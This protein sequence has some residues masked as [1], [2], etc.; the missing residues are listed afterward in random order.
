MAGVKT[1]Q[2]TAARL[3]RLLL[4]A[5]LTAFCL[6]LDSLA[7]GEER[8]VIDPT[9]KGVGYS[10]VLYDNTGGLPTSE[11]NVIAATPDGFLWIGGYAGLIRYDGNIFERLDSTTGLASVVSLL[12]DSKERLWVGTNESGLGLLEKG[13]LRMYRKADGLPSLSVRSI[14]EDRDGRI[15]IGTT[16]GIVV[17]QESGDGAMTMLPLDEPALDDEYIRSLKLGAD[18][19][20]YGVTK[21]GDV[22]TVQDGKM[23]GFYSSRELQLETVR[24]VLPDPR[25]PGYVYLAGNGPDLCYGRLET[26]FRG[27]EPIAVMSMSFVNSMDL[28]DDIIW[29]CADDGIGLVKDG[30]FESLGGVPMITSVEQVLA[31]YQGNLWFV[32]SQQGVMKIV[33][34]QFEDIFEENYMEDQVVY[35]TCLYNGRL[36][37]GTKDSGLVV[38]QDSYLIGELPLESAATASGEPTMD[39]DLLNTLNGVK[40]RS[41]IRD[42]QNRL[43][44]STF[45]ETS[46]M[47]YDGRTLTRFTPEDGLPSNRVRTVFE[48]RDGTF[49]AACTG[50]LAVI[51]GD[52]V[53]RVY[54]AADGIANTEI[55]TVCETDDGALLLGTD[56]GGIYAIRGEELER[57]DTDSGLLSDV[58]MRV[59]RDRTRNLY[60][61]V[62]SNSLAYMTS[63]GQIT[64]VQKFP[65]SNNFDLYENSRDEMWVLSSNGIYVIP[66]EE[67]LAN[68]EINPVYYS[69]ANGLPC[70]STANS[71]SELTETGDLYLSGTTGVAKVNIDEPFDKVSN[72]RMSVPYLEVDGERVYPDPTGVFTLPSGVKRVTVN[73]YVFT[74]SLTDP[75]VTYFLEGFEQSGTTVPR[76]E[77]MP[78]NYTN[79][80]GGEYRFVM[81]LQDSTGQIGS[82]L[83]VGIVKEKSIREMLWYQVFQFILALLL[84]AAIIQFRFHRKHQALLKKQEENRTLIREITE[85]FA[86]TIDMKDKY[87]N[88]HSTRVAK[89]TA[90]LA[91]ELGYSEEEVERYYNIALLHDIG[92]IGIPSE[93]LNKPGKLTDEEYKLIQSHSAKGYEVLKDIS[94][95]PELAIGAGAHHERP[96]GKGYPRGL[97]GEEI[98]RVAQIIAVADTFDAMYSTRPYRQRM[99]F[100]KVVSIIKEVSG[101]QLT[102]DVVDAFLRLAERGELRDPEDHGGGSIEDIDNIRKGYAEAPKKK[103]EEG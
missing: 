65:Y 43:W 21:D 44:I 54:G 94:I 7:A 11:A 17:A 72:I 61:I 60:W 98:P 12:T 100:D 45:G 47:R 81:E 92:K 19:V 102:P 27:R 84:V 14:V 22:F 48:R 36:F 28:L 25:N 80:P 40:I 56:G 85:A 90:M 89:Y 37:I 99:N 35:S 76:S 9:A 38:L 70:I 1:N 86:K 4:V 67:L 97:K 62:T 2:G 10:A 53:T 34:N 49:L 101:T 69:R 88:G 24:A 77:F 55:L 68:G 26:D 23:T 103:M 6:P 30:E 58:V 31:D 46:L 41:I 95:M 64:N 33:P 96:D 39:F 74:Y 75:Q 18:G 5:L 29:I 73:G 87:T 15:Y 50:G 16:M 59:K 91:R 51:D 83:S 66:V 42:S 71:Y 52:K 8:V 3:P 79:L 82:S 93:V 78:V 20:I 32:S 13:G 63:D 57:Y